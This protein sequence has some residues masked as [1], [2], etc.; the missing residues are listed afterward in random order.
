MDYHLKTRMTE[1][2]W[3]A[4]EDANPLAAKMRTAQRKIE[5]VLRGDQ[6][7]AY[8][9]GGAGVGKTHIINAT[10][11]A[12]GITPIRIS[13]DSYR[14]VIRAFEESRGRTPII[15]EECDQMFRSERTLNILKL[16]TD[17][18]GARKMQVWVPPARK[19]EDGYFKT[20]SC[21]NP[22]LFAMNGNIN[23][24]N[25][26]PRILQPHLQALIDREKPLVIDAAK[27][28]WWEYSVFLALR[29]GLLRR[30]ED[31]QQDVP[32]K[33][34]NAAIRWFSAN[35]W[36]MVHPSPRTLKKIA[37]IFATN[38]K[39]QDEQAH[40]YDARA[41]ADDLA[42]FLVEPSARSTRTAP[43]APDLFVT[44]RPPKKERMAQSASFA[45]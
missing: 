17:A 36:N 20:I 4:V 44:P 41:L 11:N 1:A 19:G 42:E 34:Q 31:G 22:L 33:L 15:F 3:D 45:S 13:T 39:M 8:L 5:A 26:F 30:S 23:D 18:A 38:A 9:C 37:G 14:D 32:L 10:I 2:D 40:R 12:T 35:A 16:A 6:A 29:R 28:A 25:A 7:A 43:F 21:T 27:E 24:I